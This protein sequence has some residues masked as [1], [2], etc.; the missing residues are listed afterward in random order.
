MACGI[1]LAFAASSQV[2]MAQDATPP[3]P[4]QE[5][6]YWWCVHYDCGIAGPSGDFCVL[7]PSGQAA[8]DKIQAMYP[9]CDVSMPV[10]YYGTKDE[11]LAGCGSSPL[12]TR[13]KNGCPPLWLLQIHVTYCDGNQIAFGQRGC[14]YR[15]AYCAARSIACRGARLW[16]GIRCWRFTV[17][18]R[19]CCCC[20]Q[21]R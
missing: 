11:C 20:C 17:I 2:T 7:A 8:H 21:G 1:A 10:N 14:S 13:C 18:E 5:V 4:P 6:D 19:P 3:R 15:D 16:E 9:D 12:V